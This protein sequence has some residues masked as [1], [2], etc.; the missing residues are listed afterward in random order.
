MGVFHVFYIEQMVQNCTKRPIYKHCYKLES[1]SI[2]GNTDTKKFDK[3][4]LI[5]L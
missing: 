5:N 4:L 1:I 3:L 2:K